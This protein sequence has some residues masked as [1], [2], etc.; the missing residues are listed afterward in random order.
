MCLSPKHTL[1]HQNTHCIRPVP[2]LRTALEQNL[3]A[4]GSL[5]L[6]DGNKRNLLI[7]TV[8]LPDL[9]ICL[10]C[11]SDSKPSS[12]IN[13]QPFKFNFGFLTLPA[14]STYLAQLT[15]QIVFLTPL[16]NLD[17]PKINQHENKMNNLLLHAREVPKKFQTNQQKIELFCATQARTRR[18]HFV[19]IQVIGHEK[20][21]K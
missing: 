9:G 8:F 5:S 7:S 14:N 2:H 1:E 13:D 19:K 4:F 17:V 11:L 18:L 10:F 3:K 6:N 12:I 16:S 21:G 20:S 15:K